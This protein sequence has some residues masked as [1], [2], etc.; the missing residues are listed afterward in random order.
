[1]GWASFWSLFSET[2]LVTLNSEKNGRT[3]FRKRNNI[4]LGLTELDEKVK[5]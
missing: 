3:E 5:S 1:M 2:H 4:L